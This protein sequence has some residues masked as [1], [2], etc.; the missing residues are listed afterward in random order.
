MKTAMPR[1]TA[2]DLALGVIENCRISRSL[3]TLDT[4]LNQEISRELEKL[5]GL[6]TASGSRA[7][8]IVLARKFNIKGV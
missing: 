8:R 6:P 3:I 4:P 5:C 7:V 2:L 1:A